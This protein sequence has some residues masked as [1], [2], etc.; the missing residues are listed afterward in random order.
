MAR[1]LAEHAWGVN[2]TP[3]MA[4]LMSHH[5]GRQVSS[6]ASREPHFHQKYR[7]ENVNMAKVAP[8]P[9]AHALS[10]PLWIMTFIM[11]AGGLP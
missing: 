1:T 8:R 10:Y 3:E 5:C 7:P 11:S 2:V 9:L 6:Y 4:H